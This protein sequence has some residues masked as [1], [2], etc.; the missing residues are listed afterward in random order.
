LRSYSKLQILDTIYTRGG[1]VQ[2]DPIKP[3]LKPR[4]DSALETKN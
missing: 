1:A 3:E 4:L 2:V